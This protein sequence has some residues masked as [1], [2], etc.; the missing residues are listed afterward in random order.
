[1]CRLITWN[2]DVWNHDPVEVR[3]TH[4]RDNN[5]HFTSMKQVYH[6]SNII[7]YS[8]LGK[9]LPLVRT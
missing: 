5:E 4:V 8:T 1:M 6:M 3:Y 9:A 2:V 7:L